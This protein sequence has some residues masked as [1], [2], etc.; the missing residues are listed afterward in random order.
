MQTYQVNGL[1]GCGIYKLNGPH[2]LFVSNLKPEP[3]S[4]YKPVPLFTLAQVEVNAD[5]IAAN[6]N[7][8]CQE[9]KS[10]RDMVI[11]L[12]QEGGG[13]DFGMTS[14]DLAIWVAQDKGSRL[15]G[16]LLA[17]IKAEV[18]NQLEAHDLPINVGL[19]NLSFG[20]PIRRYVS[21]GK[22]ISFGLPDENGVGALVEQPPNF[23]MSIPLYRF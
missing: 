15:T 17:Q 4:E 8:I 14:P 19:T 5:A 23:S 7:A 3:G 18:M 13:V 11:K 22:L 12:V 21:S 9:L 10:N 6:I 1:F 2:Q 16:E 20:N